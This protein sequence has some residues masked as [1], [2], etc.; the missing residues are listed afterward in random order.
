M[1]H[2]KKASILIILFSYFQVN[3]HMIQAYKFQ[4]KGRCFKWILGIDYND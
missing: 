3:M 1:C 4:T 2:S